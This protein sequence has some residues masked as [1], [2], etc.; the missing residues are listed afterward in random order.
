MVIEAVKSVAAWSVP[1]ER[2]VNNLRFQPEEIGVREAK[3]PG[4]VSQFFTIRHDF[5]C[6]CVFWI[7][8]AKYDAI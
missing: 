7:V 2:T 8:A 1:E 5:H 6:K 3:Y 4:G